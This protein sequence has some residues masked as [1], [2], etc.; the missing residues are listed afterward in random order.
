MLLLKFLLI[1]KYFIMV[2]SPNPTVL[3]QYPR[4]QKRNPATR[5]LPK[6]FQ[7]LQTPPFPFKNPI[8]NATWYFHSHGT[9]DKLCQSCI[10]SFSRLLLRGL[11]RWNNYIIAHRNGRTFPGQPI[12]AEGLNQ[13]NFF[14]GK[15]KVS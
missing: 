1:R 7:W 12:E 11:S 14:T 2:P 13:T 10:G 3:T 8:K 15:T 4:D 9:F 6:R 5:L